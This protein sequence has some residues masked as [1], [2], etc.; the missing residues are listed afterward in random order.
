MYD[1][2]VD[3]LENKKYTG[4]CFLDLSAAFDIV[5][6]SLLLQKLRL[7]GFD[8]NSVTWVS[9]YLTERKQTV[10]IEGKQSTILSVPT[11]VPQGS[12]LGPLFYTL[13]TNEL[14]ELVHNHSANQGL[15]SLYCDS[16]GLM[17]CYADDSSFSVADSDIEVISRKLTENYNNVSNFICS[18]KLKLNDEKT[19]LL[20]LAS[21]RAWRSKLSEDSLELAIE[22][23]VIIKTGVS[24]NLLG[25][26]ISQNLKWAEH[27]LLNSKS[28]IKQLGFRLTALNRICA[29]A[30]FKT[31]KML[32][33]G[34]F[35][36]KLVYLGK[37]SK[38]SKG[39]GCTNFAHFGRRMLT[40]PFSADPIWTPPKMQ[41]LSVHPPQ[42]DCTGENFEKKIL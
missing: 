39:G 14:P 36:S 23:N 22:N 3:A 30:S 15:Y 29:V 31:R 19:H 35:M 6:H 28:L 10:Y 16:C 41:V 40:P 17:C 33:D 2:W 32:A 12:I 7:Y 38:T 42:I 21:D 8:D 4:V 24:E 34:L 9:S 11:G 26:L 1:R 18:N 5:D 25:G 13:F 27:I 20:L 37:V